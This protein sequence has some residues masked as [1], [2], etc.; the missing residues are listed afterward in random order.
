MVRPHEEKNDAL[1]LPREQTID[2]SLAEGEVL[3]GHR[4]PP[5]HVVGLDALAPALY[6]VPFP[7]TKEEILDRLGDVRMPIDKRRTRLVGEIVER[8]LPEQ[9][10]TAT[11]LMAALQRVLVD[12]NA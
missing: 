4:K 11:D 12:Y 8:A 2:R 1:R 7:A 5:F 3:G 10:A 9:Y 6:T